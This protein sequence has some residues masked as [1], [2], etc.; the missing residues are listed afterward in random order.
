MKQLHLHR[1]PADVSGGQNRVNRFTRPANANQSAEANAR[2]PFFAESE[3]PTQRIE[4]INE[5]ERQ[6]DHGREPAEIREGTRDFADTRAL[7][8]PREERQPESCDR[9]S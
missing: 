4:Q 5:T 2:H 6:Q 9:K 7:D 1:L 3:A 8:K